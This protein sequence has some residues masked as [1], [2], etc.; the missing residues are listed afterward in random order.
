MKWLD[1]TLATPAENLACDEAL[2]DLCEEG[3]GEEVLRVWEPAGHFVVVGY[4]NRVAAEVD[5]AAC[6]ALRVPILRRCSGGGTV[7]QG[8]GCLNYSLILRIDERTASVSETNRTIMERHR[9]V[10]SA[11]L[12]RPVAVSGHTDLTLGGRKF[13]GNSQRRHQRALL[14]HGTFLLG[15]DLSLIGRCLHTPSR[16]PDYRQNR[17]HQD[18]VIDLSL[19]AGAI[20][21]A[22]KQCWKA[23]EPLAE[24][25]F[26]QIEQLAHGRYS[27][28]EWNFRR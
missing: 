8:P 13:S 15:F 2:L 18:F 11:L 26:E 5:L 17:R 3:R 20:K 23:D 4:A 16:Q 24:V 28:D 22:L 12:Q 21:Q 27:R 9:Q 7:L 19:P 25:P 1:L 6:D 14:F 10:L